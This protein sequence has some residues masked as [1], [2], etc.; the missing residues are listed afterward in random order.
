VD[1]KPRAA[2]DRIRDVAVARRAGALI[3]WAI[4]EENQLDLLTANAARMWREYER[5]SR[6]SRKGIRVNSRR[7]RG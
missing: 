4:H 2:E 7:I 5:R 6:R 3:V 1:S